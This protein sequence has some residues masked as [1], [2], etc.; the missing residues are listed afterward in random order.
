VVD[1][2]LIA[3]LITASGFILTITTIVTM[4][5]LILTLD[6]PISK[7]SVEMLNLSVSLV[8]SVLPAV[9]PKLLT[10]SS[11]LAVDLVLALS[12]PLM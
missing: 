8:L 5:M 9:L 3:D 1:A 4:I 7:V 11:T 12:L 2:P 10:A 6:F